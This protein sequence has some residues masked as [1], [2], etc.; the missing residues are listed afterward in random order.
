[1]TQHSTSVLVKTVT[2]ILRP[3]MC[4][5][6][7]RL[8]FP[9]QVIRLVFAVWQTILIIRSFVF[10][11]GFSHISWPSLVD[12]FFQKKTNKHIWTLWKGILSDGQEWTFIVRR[13]LLRFIF[14]TN[15]QKQRKPS[16][17]GKMLPTHTQGLNQ[18]SLQCCPTLQTNHRSR[19]KLKNLKIK[20]NH[21]S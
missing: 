3:V 7:Q 15:K 6:S 5:C 16:S 9:H 14:P 13:F 1:M 12:R 17:K 10:F 11:C 21:K 19:I 4:E 8:L 2:R 18:Q 20:K